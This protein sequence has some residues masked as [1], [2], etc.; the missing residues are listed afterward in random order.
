MPRKRKTMMKKLLISFFILGP[1][2]QM[3]FS[4]TSIKEKGGYIIIKEGKKRVQL[5]LP[6]E[7]KG[8]EAYIIKMN[9]LTDSKSINADL[10]NRSKNLGLFKKTKDD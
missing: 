7:M 4:Q 10:L 8:A 6:E 9:K 1:L 3:S 5:N 2:T